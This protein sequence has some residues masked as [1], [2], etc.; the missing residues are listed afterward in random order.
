M[1]GELETARRELLSH[2]GDEKGGERE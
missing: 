1:S 2:E